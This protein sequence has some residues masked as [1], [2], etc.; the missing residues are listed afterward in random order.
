MA[1]PNPPVEPIPEVILFEHPNFR[2]AHRHIFGEEDDLSLTSKSTPIPGEKAAFGN[3][4]RVTSSIIVVSGTWLFFEK[5]GC[6]GHH[7][8][9][10]PKGKLP[11]QKYPNFKPPNP[12]TDNAILSLRPKTDSDP[13]D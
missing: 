5:P 4:A 9:L 12:L 8:Q 13:D 1:E 10:P 7:E 2:G 3:F 11:P 6:D